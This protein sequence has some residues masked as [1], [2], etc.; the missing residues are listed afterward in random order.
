MLSFTSDPRARTIVLS[1]LAAAVATGCAGRTSAVPPTTAAVSSPNGAQR[2]SVQL[3]IKVPARTTAGAQRRP[4]YVSPATQSI[5]V[6]ITGSATQ[7][8]TANLT[9]TSSGCT[10]TLAT[11]TCTLSLSL[12]PGTYT[13]TVSTYDGV[14]GTGSVLSAGQAVNFA[15][16]AGQANMISLTL[17][18]IPHTLLVSPQ[19]AAA[20]AT[21]TTDVVLY[22]IFAAHLLAIALDADGNIIVGPGSPAFTVSHTS[23]TTYTI[24]NP[25]T[26]SPNTFTLTPASSATAGS[27]TLTASYSDA[28]CSQTGAVCTLSFNATT[29]LQPLMVENDTNI[30][31]YAPP[32]TGTPVTLS[33]Y[34]GTAGLAGVGAFD[35][36]GDLFVSDNAGHD[37][38]EYTPPYTGAPISVGGGS[39]SDPIGVVI[40]PDGIVFVASFTSNAVDAYAPPYTSRSP[41]F[42][43]TSGVNGPDML[44]MDANGDLFVSNFRGGNVTEYAPPYTSAPAA[45]AGGVSN[46]LQIAVD[47]A[48]DLFVLPVSGSAVYAFAPPYSGSP[49][50][51]TA[52]VSSASAIGTGPGNALFVGQ[53]GTNRVDRYVSP[54]TAVATAISNGVSQPQAIAFD[55]AGDLFVANG[56][57][58]TVYAPPY[59]GTPVTIT[60]GVSAPEAVELGL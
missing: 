29:H 44:A 48:G 58:V 10:S 23:G 24:A 17:N 55:D 33:G 4:A 31:V 11:T 57:S 38:D 54:Y 3:V 2:Q 28:T 52:G 49:T 30:K 16:V 20:H 34:S 35:S 1:A 6:A 18:G 12:A 32:Y 7:T 45:T 42:T 9:P 37:L 46:P 40:A 43:I 59:T 22:G 51:I 21:D 5:T 13:A 36:A 26:T 41:A 47:G 19:D 39:I 15:V 8:V 53:S 27:F 25:T 56:N 50:T 60:N 14:N